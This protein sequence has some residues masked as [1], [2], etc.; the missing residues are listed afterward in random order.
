MK[1]GRYTAFCHDLC[2]PWPLFLLPLSQPDTGATAVLVDEVKARAGS[3]MREYGEGGVICPVAPF[4]P[5][6]AA[7]LVNVSFLQCLRRFGQGPRHG[8]MR[9]H[10]DI[11]IELR[12]L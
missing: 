10:K 8:L 3:T 12:G 4:L 7:A 1:H 11:T 2:S 6:A 9:L 5:A